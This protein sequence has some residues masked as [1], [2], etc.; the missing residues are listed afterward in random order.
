MVTKYVYTMYF[1]PNKLAEQISAYIG[2][3]VEVGASGNRKLSFIIKDVDLTENQRETI[4]DNLPEFVKLF[5]TFDR[6]V[7]VEDES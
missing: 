4:R 7:V 2:H 1:E 3:E 5:Y 6:D